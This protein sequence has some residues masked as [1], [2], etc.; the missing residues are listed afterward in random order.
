M[1]GVASQGPAIPLRRI[2]GEA[3]QAVSWKGRKW[4]LQAG[5]ESGGMAFL[6][7]GKCSGLY[8]SW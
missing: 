1:V 2:G 4:E 3:S 6:S 8:R 5:V 7:S